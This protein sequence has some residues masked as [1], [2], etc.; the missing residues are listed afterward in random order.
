MSG[1]RVLLQRQIPRILPPSTVH[2]SHLIRCHAFRH[3]FATHLLEGG[4][5][6]RRVQKLLSHKDVKTTMIYTHVLNRGGRGGRGPVDGLQEDPDG[7]VC[8]NHI[9]PVEIGPNGSI[10]VEGDDSGRFRMRGLIP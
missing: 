7:K 9:T 8:R 5:N 4:Y 1:R 10:H 2:R 3:S 6:I